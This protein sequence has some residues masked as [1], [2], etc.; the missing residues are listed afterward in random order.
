MS[1]PKER[2]AL[3]VC[4][5]PCATVCLERLTPRFDV[6][7]IWFNPNLYPVEELG[8]RVDSAEKTFAAFGVEPVW[9][10]VK[11]ENWLRT[12]KIREIDPDTSLTRCEICIVFRLT[13]TIKCAAEEGCEYVTT[14]LTV[15]PQKDVDY[16][17]ATGAALAEAWGLKWLDETFRKDGGFQRS[18]ELSKKLGLY[19]QHY[20]G[21]EFSIREDT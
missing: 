5:G 6:V 2:L 14:S 4:C 10:H 7:P 13:A 18:V 1:E 12:Q 8:R 15:G 19:R 11:Y 17:H 21:C 3:H 16:I 9:L 20:C